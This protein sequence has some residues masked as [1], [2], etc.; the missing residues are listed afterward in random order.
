MRLVRSAA[1]L[2]VCV[3]F[4]GSAARAQEDLVPGPDRDGDGAVD[5][6][7][8]CPDEPEDHDGFEDVD[9]CPDDDND[10]DAVPDGI[11]QCGVEP[12]TRNGHEDDDGCPDAATGKPPAPGGCTD[13]RACKAAGDEAWTAG[14]FTTAA[15]RYRKACALDDI[16]GCFG[17]A[18]VVEAGQGVAADPGQA[19]A[20]YRFACGKRVREA[21]HNLAR[22][23]RD[24]RGALAN[25]TQ[26]KV[27]FGRAC[28]LG[29]AQSCAIL[30]RPAPVASAPTPPPAPTP[31][32]VAPQPAG[33]CADAK[34][35][36]DAGWAAFL[37][38]R[39]DEAA[40][41]G[42]RGCDL[43]A[44]RACAMLGYLHDNGFG[45]AKDPGKGL[46]LARKACAGGEQQGCHNVAFHLET[47]DA[48]TQDLVEARRLFDAACKSGI[49]LSCDRLAKLPAP[50]PLDPVVAA[51]DKK[52]YRGAAKLAKPLCDG[53]DLNACTWLGVARW[54]L[55]QKKDAVALWKRG[56]T[57]KIAWG[58]RELATS[59]WDGD[60]T[61]KD[62]RLAFEL[63]MQG[64][65][66]GDGMS[67]TLVGGWA[68]SE[69]EVDVPV[70][71]LMAKSP[72]QWFERACEL[73][74][75]DGCAAA[76]ME[77]RYSALGSPTDPARAATFS[78]KACELGHAW[79]CNDFAQ[80][81]CKG[82]GVAQDMG[83]CRTWLELA[84][85]KGVDFACEDVRR[86]FDR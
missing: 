48:G 69:D 79:S 20:L 17:I 8:K 42:Q 15:T 33:P 62:Q 47:G 64:C 14:D 75:G 71:L 26:A 80:A 39:H 4:L 2:V 25:P 32:P 9:G 45:V 81:L 41:H 78:K 70:H 12:E 56:C 21:C 52:D 18:R 46:A 37:A 19:L 44:M 24:G 55:G 16:T 10:G 58:C 5:A 28:D 57:G 3:S 73:G 53:G 60:G 30:G 43:G 77:L 34:A 61:K 51:H 27:Y 22:M 36:D 83:A 59:T 66:L 74:D 35:C 68:D 82:E 86:R 7:D 72:R 84:C 50:D 49:Q 65:D 29:L 6:Q 76:A 11:D 40:R 23:V 38:T 1:S 63:A 54:E 13:G 67:C 31:V 85:K